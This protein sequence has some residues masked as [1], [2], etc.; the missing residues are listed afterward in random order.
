MKE[1][2]ILKH[3]V[4]ADIPDEECIAAI[5]ENFK[6]GDALIIEIKPIQI[7]LGQ[8]VDEWDQIALDQRKYFSETVKPL[9]DQHPDKPIFYFGF[10]PIP[11]IIHLGSLLGSWRQI[12][13][14]FRHHRDR[15][16]Y[17]EFTSENPQ[18]LITIGLPEDENLSNR[19][20]SL[21]ISLSGKV[22]ADAVKNIVGE[23]LM[24]IIALEVEKPGYDILSTQSD[25]LLFADEVNK[26]F[27][28]ISE[29]YPKVQVVHLFAGITIE[30]AF[31][32]GTKIQPNIYP[33]IQ[34]YQHKSTAANLYQP[35][36]LLNEPEQAKVV[37]SEEESNMA[38]DLRKQWNTILTRDVRKYINSL[39]EKA[40]GQWYNYLDTAANWNA[41]SVP[42]WNHLETLVDNK[43]LPNDTINLSNTVVADGFDYDQTKYEWSIDTGFFIAV[44]R[45]LLDNKE[46]ER[47]GRLFL[48]HESLHYSCNGINKQVADDIGSFPKVVESADYQADIY[49]LLHEYAYSKL[50]GGDYEDK[51]AKEWFINTIKIMT[52]TMW[53][54][55]DQGVPIKEMQVRRMNRYLIWYWQA[56]RI[57]YS[58]GLADI[59]D[60]LSEKPVIEFSGLRIKAS[61]QRVFYNLTAM[62]KDVCEL[63]VYANGKVTRATPAN[64]K[65]LIE[66]FRE[67]NGAKIMETLEMFYKLVY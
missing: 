62:S 64:Y 46:I 61:N 32:L 54:F 35:A 3:P 58:S 65:D 34:T 20:V 8:E 48:L 39:K 23:S 36:I 12:F 22:N 33:K 4:H 52:E 44:K 17:Y 15:K 57:K 21:N 59:I 24:K 67:R 19:D 42:Y 31:I 51:N 47:A 56:I 28:R 6:T 53:S 16:W 50:P 43:L 41:F 10:A 38:G 66:G 60:I 2:I 11:L 29:K 45:R 7:P 5:P 9:I 37:F 55:D 26:I 30:A 14:M 27:A 40:T 18:K 1:Y 63:G 49:A 25:I 13:P